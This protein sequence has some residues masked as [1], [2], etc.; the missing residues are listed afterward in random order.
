MCEPYPIWATG[1]HVTRAGYRWRLLSPEVM[2]AAERA[3]TRVAGL[4]LTAAAVA[5][6]LMSPL[7]S[8][9]SAHR[10]PTASGL[11]ATLRTIPLATA[12]R[13][14]VGQAPDRVARAAALSRHVAPLAH[15]GQAPGG[16]HLTVALVG[17]GLLLAF[18]GRPLPAPAPARTPTG[19]DRATQ[20]N[21]GP[22]RAA[23]RLA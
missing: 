23:A 15:T 7:L 18:A 19:T 10:S 4:L 16:Q 17:L 14:S 5:L 21:R 13:G 12:V 1:A 3:R 11:S 9:G 22:P 6:A 20:R 2:V 8:A